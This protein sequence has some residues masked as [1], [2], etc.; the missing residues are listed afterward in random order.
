M[1]EAYVNGYGEELGLGE[2]KQGLRAGMTVNT[3]SHPTRKAD[4]EDTM[5]C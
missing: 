2:E 5:S 4:L 3:P 1:Q